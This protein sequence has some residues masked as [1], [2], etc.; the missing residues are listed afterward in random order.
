M[1]RCSACHIELEEAEFNWKIKGKKRQD[2]CK[3]CSR[4]Y[5]A[6]YYQKNRVRHIQATTENN[7]TYREQRR[8]YLLSYLSSHPCVDC[9][10]TDPVVL[11]FD[12]VR[13][14]KKFDVSQYVTRGN[15]DI[16]IEISKCEV[17]CANC[18][19]RRH[20]TNIGS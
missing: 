18:H 15:L 2:K 17:R 5:S 3:K 12:H 11:E 7:R 4:A 19:R 1:K 8:K 9:G 20:R 6:Q 14:E 13:G 16:N 10:E